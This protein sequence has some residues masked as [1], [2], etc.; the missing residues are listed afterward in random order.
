MNPIEEVIEKTICSSIE[1]LGEIEKIAILYNDGAENINIGKNNYCGFYFLSKNPIVSID[2]EPW[3]DSFLEIKVV[4]NIQLNTIESIAFGLSFPHKSI[5]GPVLNL[6]KTFEIGMPF[7]AFKANNKDVLIKYL[8]EF[9][10]YK[11]SVCQKI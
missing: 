6:D 5:D 7:D 9:F 2:S 11:D 1:D 10:D 3:D 4:Y 8:H